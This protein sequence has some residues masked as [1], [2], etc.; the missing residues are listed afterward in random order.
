MK[1]TYS[2]GDHGYKTFDTFH[3]KNGDNYGF[4]EHTAFGKGREGKKAEKD[5]KS[6]SYT[7][8][9]G[10]DDDHEGAG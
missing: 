1:Q 3:K 6:G 9:A 2:K 8:E 7:S 10:D 5:G 4:E